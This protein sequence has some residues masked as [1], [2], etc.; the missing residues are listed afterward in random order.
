VDHNSET[1]E[2]GPQSCEPES[3]SI[4]ISLTEAIS[5][6]KQLFFEKND[7]E[8]TEDEISSWE[9]AL[10]SADDSE[11]ES[12]DGI[13]AALDDPTSPVCGEDGDYVVIDHAKGV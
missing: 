8:P 5:K 13:S 3:D 11:G 1:D 2:P 9:A 7:R 4:E 6:L 10:Q 12:S